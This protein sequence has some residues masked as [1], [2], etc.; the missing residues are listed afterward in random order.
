[1]SIIQDRTREDKS[2]NIFEYYKVE[3]EDK[4]KKKRKKNKRIQE[5]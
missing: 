5:N 2:R 4:K 1:M 3:Q